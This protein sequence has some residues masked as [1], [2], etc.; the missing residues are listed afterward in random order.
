MKI[1]LHKLIRWLTI[2]SPLVYP[3]YLFRFEVAGIPFTALEVF[4]YVLFGL[5]LIKLIRDR[6]NVL[7]DKRTKWYWYVAFLLIVG[8]TIGV[9][10][11][12]LTLQIP[13]GNILNARQIAMGIWKGWVVAPILY[14]AVLTQVLRTEG[15]VKSILRSF[16]YFAT[17][18]SLVAYGFGVF[19]DG[20]TPDLRLRGFYESANYLALY[21]VPALLL[22]IVFYFQRP[23]T[24]YSLRPTHYLDLSCLTILVFTLFMTRSYAGIL[25]VFG[26]IALYVLV[27]LIKT[28]K[29]RKRI[30]LALGILVI[31]FA[32]VLATQMKTQ[33]FRQ[34]LDFKNRSSTSVRLEIY[35]VSWALI[36]KHP[37]D[38]IGPGLFQP[39]YQNTALKLF[40]RAPMEWNMPSPHNIFL[41]FWLNAGL[42]GLLA[43]LALIILAHQKFTWPL[44]A[45]WGILLHGLFDMPFWKNDLAMIFWLVVAAILVLQRVVK[46]ART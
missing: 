5:W 34:F 41:G 25:G 45:F 19:G 14:F 9:I 26:A 15:D 35:Q 31:V 8:A 2:L 22:A 44:I 46:Q 10:L 36:K 1:S 23:T 11:A 27:L 42:L 16:V 13:D 6:K 4:I 40:G 32:S 38:G 18:L 39:N 17:I 21:I 29:R 12:P 28:P 33:K 37:L 20:L 7:W 24:P 43:L 30:G 3:A